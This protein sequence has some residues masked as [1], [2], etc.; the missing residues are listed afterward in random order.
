MH[1]NRL[2]QILDRLPEIRILV[3]GD[4]F[5]DQYWSIDPKLEEVSI[6]TGLE[7]HQVVEV[8]LSP[9][10]AGTVTSNLAALQVGRIETL[11]IVGDDGN[12]F[13]LIRGLKERGIGAESMILSRE[14]FTPTYTK[15]MRRLP[16]GEEQEA[17]RLDI[18]NRSQTP[19]ELQNAVLQYL[20][21]LL[22][23]VDGV[24]IVDQVQEED[25]GVITARV[26]EE[27]SRLAREYRDKTFLADSRCRIGLFRD[28]MIKPNEKEAFEAA[29]RADREPGRLLKHLHDN[30]RRPIFLTQGRQGIAVFD[31]REHRQFP[32]LPAPEKID[33]VGAGDST[34]AAIVASLCAGAEL[35]EAAEFGNLV[36]SVTIRK[37]GTTGTAS[38][39]EVLTAGP[40]NHTN[41]TNRSG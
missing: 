5:L 29:E 11:G 31:G 24:I 1:F 7:V 15:P 39:E 20:E 33:P 25:A 6:E 34:S 3:L 38:P 21:R 36:A 4:F 8:R 23:E 19:R 2:K 40:T 9:G 37:L 17:A 28:V 13:E 14:R 32:A 27:L 16:S 35:W 41:H 22:P 12:G 30:N 18:K 26:R 10:A